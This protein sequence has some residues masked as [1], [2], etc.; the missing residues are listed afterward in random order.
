MT[1][2][3][4]YWGILLT[5]ALGITNFTLLQELPGTCAKYLLAMSWFFGLLAIGVLGLVLHPQ[6]GQFKRLSCGAY[7]PTGIYYLF[8]ILSSPQNTVADLAKRARETDWVSEL[9]YENMKLS[10]IRESK[11]RWFVLAL[12][13][14]GATLL[15][16]TLTIIVGVVG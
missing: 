6:K 8:N 5:V 9:T 1:P 13:F 14:A 15:W 10:L 12:K 3:P 16:V 11:H 2:R 7:A 4:R